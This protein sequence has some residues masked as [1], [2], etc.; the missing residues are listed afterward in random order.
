MSQ[1]QRQ[2]LNQP[3]NYTIRVYHCKY[4]RHIFQTTKIGLEKC[5]KCDHRALELI[6]KYKSKKIPRASGKKGKWL[7]KWNLIKRECEDILIVE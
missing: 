4:C 3:K 1:Y 2:H 6:D 5:D 7:T